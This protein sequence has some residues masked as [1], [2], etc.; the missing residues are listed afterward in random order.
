MRTEARRQQWAAD[1]EVLGSGTLCDQ[2][3]LGCLTAV[4][5][6]VTQPDAIAAV[7]RKLSPRFGGV[8]LW[9]K[10]SRLSVSCEGKCPRGALLGPVGC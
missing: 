1:H 9:N 4:I 5:D 10:E 2:A 3:A 6:H 8:F 7:S